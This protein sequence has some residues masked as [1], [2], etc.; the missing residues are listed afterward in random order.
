MSEDFGFKFME[1]GF[2]TLDALEQYLPQSPIILEEN[3]VVAIAVVD[4]A[5]EL[6]RHSVV[7]FAQIRAISRELADRVIDLEE[8]R[9]ISDLMEKRYPESWMITLWQLAD[10]NPAAADVGA[11]IGATIS[12][13]ARGLVMSLIKHCDNL[14]EALETY[15]ANISLVNASETWEVTHKGNCVELTF[16]FVSGDYPRCAVE[17]SMISM[18]HLAGYLCEQRIPIY[19]VE[20]S[21]QKPKYNDFLQ[22]LFP[23]E[24]FF[25]SDR[26]AL[27]FPQEASSILLP[28]HNSH[29]KS[30]LEQRI[31]SLDLPEPEPS[32]KKR[33]LGLLR[34]NLSAYRS[35][36][37][38]AQALC[39]SRV[40][41]YRK[42]KEEKT[43]FFRLLESERQ[44]LFARNRHRP[45]TQL[46]DL[47]GFRDT[48]AYYKAR[49][50]WNV[51]LN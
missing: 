4:L 50:R 18:Y 28:Q 41:L 31:S 51:N 1:N 10:A 49:K 20:F 48:S 17:R 2:S 44:R 19:A 45:A 26:N 37:K 7:D 39:M 34:Q 13:E 8:G 43:S 22:K 35:V 3:H 15:L 16:R 46:C 33:V 29:L 24:I 42:L 25:D 47:L 21:F 32:V 36:E 6:K 38:S 11:R 27:V 40:T 30:I 9:D 5:R 23:C 14:M 12:P